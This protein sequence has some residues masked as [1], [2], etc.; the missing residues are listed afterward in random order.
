MGSVSASQKCSSFLCLCPKTV[1]DIE[2]HSLLDLVA[3]GAVS[4]PREPQR[5]RATQW[6][7]LRRTVFPP[8]PGVQAPCQPTVR[9]CGRALL[10]AVPVPL[11]ELSE[12]PPGLPVSPRSCRPHKRPEGRLRC[13]LVSSCSLLSRRGSFRMPCPRGGNSFWLFSP[14]RKAGV[15]RSRTASSS[16]LGL[17]TWDTG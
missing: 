13:P 3:L 15:S 10:R 12:L 7:S 14:G 8:H 4:V 5:P 11:V 2:G 17:W 16:R 6:L 1:S 9:T